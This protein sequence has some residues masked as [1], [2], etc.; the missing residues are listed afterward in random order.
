MTRP[1][2][3]VTLIM[4][5]GS[6]TGCMVGPDPN[7]RPT[8][9]LPHAYAELGVERAD[10]QATV[11]TSWAS[12][13]DAVML[14]L[15]D[16][17]LSANAD[18]RVA[19]ARVA[20]ARSILG[21]SEADLY[22]SVDYADLVERRRESGNVNGRAGDA[23][24]DNRF[25]TGLQASWEIDL[26]GRVRRSV[27]AATFDAIE[28]EGLYLDARRSLAAEIAS[29]YIVA[30]GT[31]QRIEV[32]RKGVQNQE[33]LLRITQALAT[34]GTATNADIQ[35]ITAR[36]ERTRAAIPT[37]QSGV[38]VS[39]HRLGVLCGSASEDIEAILNQSSALPHMPD[40][41]SVGVPAT[42]LRSRPDIASVESA[43]AA[44]TARV[45]VA[46]ADL[47]PRVTLLGDFGV[48]SNDFDNLFSS[49]SL[50]FGVGP[51]LR[52][53]L[54]DFGRVRAN[55]RAQGARQ[56]AAMA[57]YEQRVRDA[58]SEVEIA[59]AER[60]GFQSQAD[61]LLAASAAATEAQRLFQLRYDRGAEALIGVL[62]AERERL[63]I[64]DLLAAARV[65]ALLSHAALLRALIADVAHY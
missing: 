42:L 11:G 34:S 13:D 8:V 64:D 22:P 58:L 53:P 30:V 38:R 45:G 4:L 2:A 35:R 48:E 21:V 36:L 44:A 24:T 61:L 39:I 65:R 18:L 31:K 63:E 25:R 60:Q 46:T 17:G 3:T 9:P 50:A 56:Q 57:A 37:L 7:A 5:A 12:F 20:E 32:A 54:L 62:D 33:Q 41:P 1:C 29:E 43:L 6:L 59:L 55:I 47:F 10:G 52:W 19:S 26:W 40:L 28:A 49:D 51:S 16:I 23:M 15:I 27:E 14:T